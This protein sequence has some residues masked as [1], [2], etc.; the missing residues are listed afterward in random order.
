MLEQ[1]YSP[2][3]IN[4]LKINSVSGHEKVCALYIFNWI[5]SN[6]KY[7]VLQLQKV[8]SDRFNVILKK[9]NP[10]IT[11]SSHID[12]VPGHVPVIEDNSR[13][14]GRGACDAKGQIATQLNAIQSAAMLGLNNY[15]CFFVIGEEVDSVGAKFAIKNKHVGSKY[16]INGEPTNNNFVKSAKGIMDILIYTNATSQHTSIKTFESAIH[17]LI[18]DLNNLL[19]LQ[20]NYHLNIGTIKGGHA[21]NVSAETAEA[22]LSL[23]VSD[24][25]N[26]TINKIKKLLR[27]SKIKIIHNPNKLVKFYV[28]N[29][30][31]KTF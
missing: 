25:P 12:T 17:K 7:D 24:N 3:L 8:T 5:K 6:L 9:G 29:K 22:N 27:Y 14:Y 16:L 23:R 18:T 1:S 2:L 28:P 4:L 13:I 15:V 10:Q 21:L 19:D 11:L 26:K 30:Y 31:K 20:N